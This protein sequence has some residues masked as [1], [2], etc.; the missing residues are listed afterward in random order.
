MK[1]VKLFV[2]F[3]CCL[4]AINSQAQQEVTLLDSN[5]FKLGEGVVLSKVSFRGLCVVNDQIIWASGS[6]GTVAKSVDGGKTFNF[7]QLKDYPK[8]DFRDIEAFDDKTA[9]MLSSGTPAYI[10]KTIDGGETWEEIYKNMDTAVF[11]DAMDFWNNQK[12]IIVGDPIKGKFLLLQTLNGGDTWKLIDQKYLPKAEKGEAIFAASGTSLK[13]WGNNEFGFV[14]GGMF[15]SFYQFKSPN[16][17]AKKINLTIQ[18]GANGKGAFSFVKSNKTFIAV[19]GDYMKDSVRYK[20]YDEIGVNLYYEDMGSMPFG[21]RSCIEKLNG[22]IFIACGSNGVDV[23]NYKTKI[24]KNIN[25]QNFN[26][27]KKAKVGNAVFI[28]GNKGKIGKVN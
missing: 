24:W 11:L 17:I 21:Y 19:G 6:R 1:I 26:V 28:A 2:C 13:C 18:Q 8:S 27:V 7:Q 16:A 22:N 15:S 10:L 14:T 23:F 4:L 9:V 3:L 5:T 25:Q 12:G 20:N